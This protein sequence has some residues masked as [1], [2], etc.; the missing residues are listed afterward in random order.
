[1]SSGTLRIERDGPIGYVVLANPA[2]RNAISASMWHA[3]P[4][5]IEELSADAFDTLHRI[6]W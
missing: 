1:M 6:A 4:R 3:F 5:V 2:R